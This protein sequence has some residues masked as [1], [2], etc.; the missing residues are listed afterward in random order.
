MSHV[1]VNKVWSKLPME[2][3]KWLFDLEQGKVKPRYRG[4]YRRI[5]AL[6]FKYALNKKRSGE[7]AYPIYC[8][9]RC[10]PPRPPVRK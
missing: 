7:R 10:K 5:S 9:E 8:R 1:S 6:H 2:L 4:Q 3:D